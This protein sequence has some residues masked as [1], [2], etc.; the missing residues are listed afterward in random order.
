MS[1]FK[2]RMGCQSLRWRY[3]LL[4]I[5]F[6][7]VFHIWNNSAQDTIYYRCLCHRLPVKLLCGLLLDNRAWR[8]ETKYFSGEMNLGYFGLSVNTFMRMKKIQS[9]KK[10]IAEIIGSIWIQDFLLY[11]ILVVFKKGSH[12][13]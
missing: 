11:S 9:I 12:F 7:H 2:I 5:I 4:R 6:G 8:L 3:Y 13:I 1:G 10:R